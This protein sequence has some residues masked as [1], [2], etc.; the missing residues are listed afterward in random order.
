VTLIPAYNPLE[1]D[2]VSNEDYYEENIEEQL[3]EE[4]Y[5]EE[6]YTE[7]T[8]MPIPVDEEEE[9]VPSPAPQPHS[10]ERPSPEVVWSKEAP[11][12]QQAPP[13]VQGL[14][15]VCIVDCS[16]LIKFSLLNN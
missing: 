1:Y 6:E 16:V 2:Y 12:P 7:E 14:M 8:N 13:Q 4:E 10:I 3:T 11:Q 9:E 15:G 5:Q